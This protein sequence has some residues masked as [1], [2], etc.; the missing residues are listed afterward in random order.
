MNK[1]STKKIIKK[2]ELSIK[3]YE[4]PLMIVYQYYKDTR[5]LITT[6]THFDQT[7]NCELISN[8][9]RVSSRIMKCFL[10]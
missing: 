8:K 4:I 2:S 5:K 3:Q 10:I 7:V 6:L 1:N 9:F